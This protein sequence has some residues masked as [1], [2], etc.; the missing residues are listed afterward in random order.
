MT[1]RHSR[2]NGNQ[3][4]GDVSP[5]LKATSRCRTPKLGHKF[6]KLPPLNPPYLNLIRL[7][8]NIRET[9]NP[10]YGEKRFFG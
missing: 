10:S 9:V 2:E 4:A 6:L 7:F 1:P 5:G 3:V 8:A